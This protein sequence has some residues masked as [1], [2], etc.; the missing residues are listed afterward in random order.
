MPMEIRM[1][2]ADPN[3]T[4]NAGRIALQRGPI[5]YSIEMAGNAQLNSDIANFSP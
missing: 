3:V 2:E 5:V 1:T 4:T